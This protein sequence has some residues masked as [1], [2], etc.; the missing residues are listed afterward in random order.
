MGGLTGTDPNLP[1][2]AKVKPTDMA[3][4][5]GELETT[6]GVQLGATQQAATDIISDAQIQALQAAGY[7]LKTDADTVTGTTNTITDVTNQA[8][9]AQTLKTLTDTVDPETGKPVVGESIIG[10]APS[11]ESI[12]QIKATGL[13]ATDMASVDR[14]KTP[15][16]GDFTGNFNDCLLYTSPSP[17]D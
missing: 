8:L 1:E 16:V 5:V 2:T 17:R 15:T 13:A 11:R 9:N 4:Q 6:A 12:D 7:T 14:R 10:S 3:A